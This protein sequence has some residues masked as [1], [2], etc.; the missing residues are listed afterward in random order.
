MP[1]VSWHG[2]GI[3]ILP[4]TGVNGILRPLQVKERIDERAAAG[5]EFISQ[6]S[7]KLGLKMVRYIYG[8]SEGQG[9]RRDRRR[10]WSDWVI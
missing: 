5:E 4:I 2:P 1:K 8:E 10:K 6:K 7:D 3:A 9:A